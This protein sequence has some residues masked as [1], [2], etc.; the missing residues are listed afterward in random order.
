MIEKI[1][2]SMAKTASGPGRNGRAPRIDDTGP[3]RGPARPPCSCGVA[4]AI[5]DDHPARARCAGGDSLAEHPGARRAAHGSIA[6]R[7]SRP[8]TSWSPRAGR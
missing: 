3:A 5:S 4:A 7:S 6:T 8:T 1:M 2:W